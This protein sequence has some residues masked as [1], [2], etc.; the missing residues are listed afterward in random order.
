MQ[1]FKIVFIIS[2]CMGLILI[3]A[4]L[5]P[6]GG[7]PPVEEP[8]DDPTPHPTE[9]PTP[10]PNSPYAAGIRFMDIDSRAGTIKG[11]VLINRAQDESN[12][13]YYN[14]YFGSTE[15]S[16]DTFLVQLEP[17]G[18]NL[19]YERSSIAL[20]PG[21]KYFLVTTVS[22]AG[23]ENTNPADIRAMPIFDLVVE[24][25]TDI[26]P[27][28]GS[29]N[30]QNM[31]E[32]NSRLY[33][34]A[35]DN[36]ID[37]K[38]MYYD[39]GLNTVT[40]IGSIASP[41]YLTVFNGKL[42]FQAQT[43]AEGVELWSCDSSNNLKLVSDIKPGAASSIPKNFQVY[44]APG[45]AFPRLYFQA[46]GTAFGSEL[47]SCDVN[48]NV[49]MAYNIN[50]SGDSYPEYLTVFQNKLYFVALTAEGTKIYSYDGT[51]EP[52][53]INL[54]G[55]SPQYLTVYKNRL[56]FQCLFTLL[57]LGTEVLYY[58]G[59]A[60][61]YFADINPKAGN[62]NPS[63]FMVYA[64]NLYFSATD[65][66]DNYEL[67]FYDEQYYYRIDFNPYGSSNPAYLTVNDDRLFF[68]A[69]GGENGKELWVY[70]VFYGDPMEIDL[71]SG[72]SSSSPDNLTVYGDK[73]YFSA[74]SGDGSGRE[75]YR[76]YYKSL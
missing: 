44:Q 63:N 22:A 47:Y 49:T 7:L 14:L 65:S 61:N 60:V 5:P 45:D 67:Y 39:E 19:V 72:S 69:D 15:S 4:C 40:G 23:I 28:S 55:V 2:L 29:S 35:T 66:A 56:Y 18:E 57:I 12:V 9:R 26:N 53:A 1:K 30:P 38:L 59:T 24:R 6:D 34:K 13:R 48:D 3:P 37:N 68:Q 32:Y 74:D 27:G 16:L 46:S 64:D 76:A 10:P 36:S 11:N 43:D 42:Y 71:F 62:S 70:D 54:P 31:Q 50:K 21:I 58:D 33:F 20:G 25:E 75:L 51:G 17:T 73:L 52:Q 8:N 41:D